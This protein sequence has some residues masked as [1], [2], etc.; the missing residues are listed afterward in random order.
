MNVAD[1][2]KILGFTFPPRHRRAI[3]DPSDPIHER[4]NFLVARKKRDGLDLVYVNQR[5]RGVDR[6]DP[7]PEFLIAFSHSGCGDYFAYDIRKKPATIIYID[8]DRTVQENLDDKSRD[9]LKYR[10][11][12]AWYKAELDPK[13]RLF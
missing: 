1:V 7:W 8:P 6:F 3:L 11:F 12:E 13:R 4:R 5:L 10:T 9:K 2:E